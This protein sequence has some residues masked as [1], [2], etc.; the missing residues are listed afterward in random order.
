MVGARYYLRSYEAN[1][2]RLDPRLDFRSPRDMNG[3]GTHT[4]STVGGRRV[5]NA[6]AVGGF[7]S[8]TASGGAPLVRLATYKVCWPIPEEE[9]EYTCLDDDMLAAFDDAIADGVQVISVS[10]GGNTSVPYTRD[11]TAIGA[12]HA[13]RRNIV[14]VCSAGNDG[15]APFTVTNVAPW[16]ITVG[17]SSIDRVFSSPV[18]LGN[19]LVAEVC[20]T[21]QY[22]NI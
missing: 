14:V 8:G 9:G 7:G 16:I 20:I 17:A 15:P 11:G 18:E 13:V 12:L 4:S 10:I 21:L 22:I 3:H 1:Y 6:A 5:A 2:G 19:G